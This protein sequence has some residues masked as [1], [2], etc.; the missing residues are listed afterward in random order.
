MDLV[1]GLGFIVLGVIIGFETNTFT[2]QQ[3]KS[4]GEFAT[5]VLFI[6]GIFELVRY[7]RNRILIT[8]L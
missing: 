5:V 2:D 6:F 3:M 7:S 1:A 8:K 4:S